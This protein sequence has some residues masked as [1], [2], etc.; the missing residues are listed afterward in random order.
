MRYIKFNSETGLCNRIKYMFSAIYRSG[1]FTE[2]VNLYWRL[3]GRFNRRFG[4]LFCFKLLKIVEDNDYKD[5]D[6]LCGERMGKGCTW[7]LYTPT[8]MLPR[9]FTRAFPRDV[10][11]EEYIDLEYD[12]IPER[13]QEIYK[14]YFNCLEPSEL[15]RKRISEVVLPSKCVGVHIRLSSEWI[16]WNR[17]KQDDVRKYIKVMKR[18]PVDTF[19]YLASYDSSVAQIV[20]EEFPNR[21][22]ELPNKNYDDLLDAVADL[23]LLSET[24]ELIV[25]YGSTFSEVAWWLSG[26]SQKVHIVGSYSKWKNGGSNRYYGWRAKLRKALI[27]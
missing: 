5:A 8:S 7:R 15:A 16:E 6:S 21:I 26:C 4:E 22:I 23:Y 1:D 2:P 20:K 18:F 27:R 3:E 9:G 10:H 24:R 12:R 19:F 25:T 14:D 17:G 11:G 13:V